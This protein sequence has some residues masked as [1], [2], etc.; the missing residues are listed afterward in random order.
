MRKGLEILPPWLSSTELG[1]CASRRNAVHVAGGAEG[2]VGIPGSPRSNR[3][4]HT[5]VTSTLPAAPAARLDHEDGTALMALV[6]PLVSSFESPRRTRR[7]RRRRAANCRRC[8]QPTV[9]ITLPLRSIELPTR[10]TCSGGGVCRAG[11]PSGAR[12][13][14]CRLSPLPPG[15]NPALTPV[16][17]AHPVVHQRATQLEQLRP[18][19][20]RLGR[21]RHDVGKR[22]LDGLPT[23]VRTLR[24][25]VSGMT[26][27]NRAERPRCPVAGRA[28]RAPCRRAPS[29]R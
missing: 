17:V 21:V 26:S 28:A 18:R 10:A 3:V 9:N 27:G 1:G 2:T 23:V 22:R 13:C 24:R 14:V 7:A 12:R 5:T 25:P 4:M 29:R 8:R 15:R 16:H 6:W 19:V 11:S 20:G